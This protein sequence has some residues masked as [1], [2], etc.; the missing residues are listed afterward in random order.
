MAC[1]CDSWI[2]QLLNRGKEGSMSMWIQVRVRSASSLNS[3]ACNIL[4]CCDMGYEHT[5]ECIATVQELY[6][7]SGMYHTCTCLQPSHHIHGPVGF[8]SVKLTRQQLMSAP[9]SC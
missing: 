1:G 3:V 7:R 2:Q 5:L 4:P 9:M 6:M 8:A